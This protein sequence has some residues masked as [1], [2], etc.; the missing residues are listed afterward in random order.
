[1][2]SDLV[3]TA[4]GALTR[5]V[6]ITLA[7]GGA[8][9]WLASPLIAGV[10]RTAAHELGA[11][12]AQSW[13]E[14]VALVLGAAAGSWLTASAGLL[15]L[16]EALALTGRP[17]RRS[18][19]AASRVAPT[20][21]R[22]AVGVGLGAALGLVPQ[23]ALA[24]EI[25]LG[26]SSGEATAGVTYAEPRAA[27]PEASSEVASHVTTVDVPVAA[28]DRAVGTADGSRLTVKPGD[29]LWSLT[30]GALRHAGAAE[31]DSTVAR[32]WPLLWQ[33]NRAVL[34]SDP[35]LIHPGQVLTLPADLSS[36]DLSS[37]DLITADPDT[38]AK[39]IP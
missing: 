27:D 29:T 26:W 33:H 18:R 35:D 5:A 32:T 37:A 13:V 11:F 19:A 30:R 4:V 16:V 10:H 22:R 31:D 24:Q 2:D 7:C 3:R 38:L 39:E 34:G 9:A 15:T 17:A 25:D 28:I 21:L 20:L 12:P 6:S 36:A 8:T 23:A 14:L 1:M